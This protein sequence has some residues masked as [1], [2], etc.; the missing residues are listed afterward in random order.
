MFVY[1]IYLSCMASQKRCLEQFRTHKQL[2]TL[3]LNGSQRKRTKG[4][5]KRSMMNYST[6]IE[7][8]KADNIAQK[9]NEK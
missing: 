7:E 5:R 6:D 3:L 9:V 2:Q 8:P 1:L 4:T